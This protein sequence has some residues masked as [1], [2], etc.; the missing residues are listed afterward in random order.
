MVLE[1][2]PLFGDLS[3][4]GQREHLKTPAVGKYRP[5]PP[6]EFVQSSLPGDQLFSG[7]DMEMVG[8][9]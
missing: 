2:H 1:M 4:P 3:Q 5:L 8:I 9:S 6:H 7:P